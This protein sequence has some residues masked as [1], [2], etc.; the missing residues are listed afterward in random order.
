MD[1]QRSPQMRPRS[2][3]EVSKSLQDTPRI[4]QELILEPPR[5]DFGGPEGDFGVPKANFVVPRIDFGVN[6]D[7]EL[8]SH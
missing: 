3:K 8:P 6:Q 5:I 7:T 4:L 1:A 2:S